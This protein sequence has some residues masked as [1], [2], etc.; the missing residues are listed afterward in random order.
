MGSGNAAAFSAPAAAPGA[1]M[2]VTSFGGPAFDPRTG[3]AIGGASAAAVMDWPPA[4]NQPRQLQAGDVTLSPGETYPVR[5]TLPAPAMLWW[6]FHTSAPANTLQFRVVVAGDGTAMLPQAKYNCLV[7]PGC[8][9][10]TFGK[11]TFEFIFDNR[12]SK[13]KKKPVHFE[14]YATDS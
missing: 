11:G 1:P 5:I 9:N 13:F 12:E 14:I 8:G 3:A 10:L 4:A 2:D 7:E 6:T